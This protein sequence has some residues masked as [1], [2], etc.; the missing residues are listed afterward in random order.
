MHQLG[1]LA[2]SREQGEQLEFADLLSNSFKET[3]KL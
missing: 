2:A 1:E 3:N